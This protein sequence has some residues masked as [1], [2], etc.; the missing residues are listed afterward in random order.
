MAGAPRNFGARG[1]TSRA[2]RRS[3]C[4]VTLGALA[5][6]APVD[7]GPSELVALATWNARRVFDGVCDS[8]RCGEAEPEA[9]PEPAELEQSLARVA[10]ALGRLDADAVVVTEVEHLALLRA[11]AQRSGGWDTVVM[12][13][14]GPGTIDV[15][16]VARWPLLGW[17]QHR[18]LLELPSGPTPSTRALLEVHLAVHGRRW[19]VL[20]AHLKSKRFD[21]PPRRVAEAAALAALADS[22]RRRYP[23]ALLTLAGDFN[24]DVGSEALDQLERTGELELL[25]RR[26]PPEQ[27]YTF[28]SGRRRAL[29]DHLLWRPLP[30][31]EVSRVEV[32]RDTGDT[33]GG[34][35]HA[36][37]RAELG[38][39]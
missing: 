14:S 17:A 6:T 9:V 24:D 33:F 7:P 16:V 29:L 37:L 8:G 39:R 5:C 2:M 21:D 18:P 20:G 26:L 34:S 38:W 10:Q 25:T 11:V 23:D 36:A 30:G 32:L 19:I 12:A 35:D 22:R 1:T 13:E 15:G 27:A 31:S 28:G 3:L 4:L